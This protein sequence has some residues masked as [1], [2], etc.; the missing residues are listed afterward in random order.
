MVTL[1]Q[2]LCTAAGLVADRA[3]QVRAPTRPRPVS[4]IPKLATKLPP[5]GNI[6]TAGVPAPLAG[7]LASLPAE[8]TG[9]T[10]EKRSKFLS[11][12]EAVL[13]FCIPIIDDGKEAAT[14]KKVAS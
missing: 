2:G 4:F 7:L 5:A 1:F 14:T 9:W 8:G 6:S 3:S 10:R 12:F 13:D 11:T